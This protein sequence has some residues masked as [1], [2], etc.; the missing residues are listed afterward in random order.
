MSQK[1]GS[2]GPRSHRTRSTLQHA[3]TNYGTHRGNGSVHTGCT[4]HQRVCTQICVQ[5]CL[6]ILSERGLRRCLIRLKEAKVSFSSEVFKVHKRGGVNQGRTFQRGM[7]SEIV[8]KSCATN[9]LELLALT[10]PG[11]S[12][13]C[14]RGCPQCWCAESA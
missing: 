11:F 13:C 3:H 10:N 6:R 5:I 4:Q 1:M 7:T 9:N 14:W 8:A 12:P 2:F